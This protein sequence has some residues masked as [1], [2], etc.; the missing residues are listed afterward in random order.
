MRKLN[1]SDNRCI[2]KF[3]DMESGYVLDFSNRTFEEF[4]QDAVNRNIFDPKYN[5]S[6]NSKANLL[7]KFF[8]IESH[9]TIGTLL[10][11]FCKYWVVHLKAEE[12]DKQDLYEECLKI[13]DRLKKDNIIPNISAIEPDFND[14]KD[15]KLLA[16][17]IRA[18]IGK[19]NPEAALARLHTFLMKFFRDL[20]INHTI[21]YS[22]EDPLH[23]LSGKYF[24][25]I[26]IQEVIESRVSILILKSSISILDAFNEVRNNRS[27][28]HDN[29]LLN[30]KESLLIFN[31][32]VNLVDFIKYIEELVKEKK[33]SE[34][35][36][37][38]VYDLPF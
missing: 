27:F 11:Q 28:A 30:Y 4:I 3:L 16:D 21:K 10:E 37:S 29:P 36:N 15:F 13:A 9:Y 18:D 5:Y 12:P 7:R 24:K 23:S 26:E 17:S 20:C 2:E 38:S 1:F 33:E 6:S 22:D 31:N 32:I 35:S 8:Q 25:F 34:K 19:N 14:P